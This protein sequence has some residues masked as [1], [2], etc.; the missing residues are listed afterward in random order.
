MTLELSKKQAGNLWNFVKI[1]SNLLLS[2]R[3][4]A[5]LQTSGELE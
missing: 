4:C 2:F 3:K 5:Q 1:N